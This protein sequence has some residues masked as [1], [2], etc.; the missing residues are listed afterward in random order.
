MGISF[1]TWLAKGVQ[2]RAVDKKPLREWYFRSAQ[3]ENLVAD[4]QLTES[5]D[6]A[7]KGVA[8]VY[9]LACDMGG[10]GFI[11][12]NRARCML[13]VLTSTHMLL[14]ARKHGVARFF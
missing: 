6:M 9:N 3:T 8:Q 5:C 1:P 10:M 7:T 12:N 14:A 2:V 11:E 4:L 13:S